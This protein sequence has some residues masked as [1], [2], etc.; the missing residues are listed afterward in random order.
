MNIL[1]TTRAARAAT[2]ASERQAA[3]AIHRLHQHAIVQVKDGVARFIHTMQVAANGNGGTVPHS[4]AKDTS[5]AKPI[6]QAMQQFGNSA[7]TVI[8]NEQVV[9]T[10]RGSIMA[11]QQL[12]ATV[13]HGYTWHFTQPDRKST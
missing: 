9:A 10:M 8:S 13:P 1:A 6:A 5:I 4:F 11:Q 12:R 2:L 7:R 3:L